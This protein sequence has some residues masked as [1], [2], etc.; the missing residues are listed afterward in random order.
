M[1]TQTPLFST[2]L[3]GHVT[4]HIVGRKT[5]ANPAMCSPYGVLE[6]IALGP[7]HE[8]VPNACDQSQGELVHRLITMTAELNNYI[9]SLPRGQWED[10][11]EKI[12]SRCIDLMELEHGY[13]IPA[14]VAFLEESHGINPTA[15]TGQVAGQYAE[16]ALLPAG[17]G[18]VDYRR[19][20]L[21]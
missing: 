2:P 15:E 7:W 14:T 3:A 11:Q 5:G 12:V 18:I 16:F 9:A 10:Y 20:E 8:D 6:P 19:Q 21:N 4:P 17:F 1:N 13:C